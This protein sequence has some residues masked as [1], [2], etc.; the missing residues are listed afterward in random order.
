MGLLIAFAA[1]APILGVGAVMD[2]RSRRR[3][4]RVRRAPSLGASLR[5]E[6]EVGLDIS[7]LGDS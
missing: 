1:I 3:R 4:H 2:L 7:D 6:M 5:H